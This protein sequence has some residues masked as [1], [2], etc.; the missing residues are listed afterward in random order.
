M[1]TGILDLSAGM[2]AEMGEV[3]PALVAWLLE[4]FCGE[5]GFNH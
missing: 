5:Q 2:T 3:V 1:I 4:S